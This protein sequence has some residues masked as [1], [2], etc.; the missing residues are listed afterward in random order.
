MT[1]YDM[2]WHDMIWRDMTWYDMT[3]HDMTWHDMTW[4]DMT[5]YDMTKHKTIHNG[6]VLYC[7]LLNYF[8]RGNELTVRTG[9]L[10]VW[11]RA[12]SLPDFRPLLLEPCSPWGTQTETDTETH[13]ENYH[14]VWCDVMWGWS[15]IDGAMQPLGDRDAERESYNVMW[16]DV[17]WCDVMWCDTV[18]RRSDGGIECEGGIERCRVMRGEGR[19]KNFLLCIREGSQVQWK[20]K[21]ALNM[22]ST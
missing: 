18:G 22:T 14:S 6:I 21:Y 9:P 11:G 7:I 19:K 8:R 16:C 13:T 10:T 4:H 5:W 20:V 1:W 12:G 3:W 2:T 17:M 15:V